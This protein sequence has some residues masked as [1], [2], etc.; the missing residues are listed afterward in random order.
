VSTEAG[1]DQIAPCAPL[2]LTPSQEIDTYCWPE[3]RLVWQPVLRNVRFH[4]RFSPAF[5]DDRALHVLFDAA[6]TPTLTPT[7]AARARTLRAQIVAAT[8]THRS[9]PFEPLSSA[10]RV[11]FEQ[12]RDRVAHATVRAAIALRDPSIAAGAFVG[13]GLRPES[14]GDARTQDALRI[15]TLSFLATW[16]PPSAIKKLTAFSL[17]EGREPAHLDEWVFLSFAGAAGRITPEP[18]TLVS[19]RDGRTLVDLGRSLTSGMA[20][21]DPRFLARANDPAV[22][23]EIRESVILNSN[24]D[25]AR[26]LPVLRDRRQRLVPNTS[27]ASCHRLNTLRFDLHNFGYLEDRDLTISPRVVTDVELDL[28]WMRRGS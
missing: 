9:G 10:E 1:E 14:V 24:T 25:E 13:L 22:G 26:L 28:A 27:C 3:I 2:G 11:E 18:I 15:R 20:N 16:A 8:K 4:A 23:A 5:A 21:D 12:Y 7:E 6:E 17:P 19:P